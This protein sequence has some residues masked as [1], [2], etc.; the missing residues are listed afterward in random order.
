MLLWLQELQ[1]V[2]QRQL[3]LAVLVHQLTAMQT[4]CRRLLGGSR[5]HLLMKHP[6]VALQLR[7][8][9]GAAPNV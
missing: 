5:S 4:V 7:V 9:Q 1:R 8:W 2:L 3:G 6:I